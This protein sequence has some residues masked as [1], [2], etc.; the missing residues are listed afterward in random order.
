M[1]RDAK[2]SEWDVLLKLSRFITRLDELVFPENPIQNIFCVLMRPE[3]DFGIA[4]YTP[5]KVNS[6]KK[7]ECYSVFSYELDKKVAEE[8]KERIKL[9]RQAVRGL[10]NRNWPQIIPEEVF[11]STAVH[12]VRH[13]LQHRLPIRFFSS[14]DAEEINDP[15]MKAVVKATEV[16]FKHDPPIGDYAKEFDAKVIEDYTTTE[17][18]CGER[19]FAKIAQ[20]I[21]LEPQYFY[22]RQSR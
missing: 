21:K 20:L 3:K 11:I 10:R 5:K 9:Q 16:L 8:V 17:W 18:H 22:R 19:D 12:E 6:G 7:P 2:K 1:E 4:A 14:D 15:L 13:R